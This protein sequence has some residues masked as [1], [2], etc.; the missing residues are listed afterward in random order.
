MLL[1]SEKPS[2]AG[3]NRLLWKWQKGSALVPAQLGDPVHTTNF[4]LCVYAGAVNAPVGY[5]QLPPGKGW[6]AVATT[7]YKFVGTSP[8]GISKVLLKSGESGKANAL[9]K[10]SGAALPKPPL[11][12]D[13]PVR[14]QLIRD[15]GSPFC[16]E[17]VFSS[18]DQIQNDDTVFKALMSR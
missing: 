15:D 7:G 3:R 17:S 10:G 16:I 9:A 5:A 8:N 6:S 2:Q 11:P 13:Y 4:A 14:I 18:V 1:V 12:F